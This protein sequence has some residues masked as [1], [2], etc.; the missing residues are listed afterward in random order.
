MSKQAIGTIAALVLASVIQLQ[1]SIGELAPIGQSA[2]AIIALAVVLW[3]TDVLNVGI[4]AILALGLLIIAGVPSGV[5]LG[6][7]AGPL[8]GAGTTP[9][10]TANLIV[11]R[12]RSLWRRLRSCSE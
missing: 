3:V 11:A 2:L 4:T 8:A 1:P 9:C 6:G 5:A 7:F 12:T 10:F